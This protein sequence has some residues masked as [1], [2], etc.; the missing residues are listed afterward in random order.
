MSIKKERKYPGFSALRR[1][2]WKMKKCVMLIFKK[3]GLSFF[4]LRVTQ[5]L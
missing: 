4:P 5:E 3:I 1:G 2:L